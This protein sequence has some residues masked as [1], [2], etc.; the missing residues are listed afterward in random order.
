MFMSKE[1]LRLFM[2]IED[3]FDMMEMIYSLPSKRLCERVD[4]QYYHISSNCVLHKPENVYVGLQLNKCSECIHNTYMG[5]EGKTQER[6]M[7]H[8]ESI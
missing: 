8:F 4:C 6:D 5:I 3:A 7:D 2:M 1:E